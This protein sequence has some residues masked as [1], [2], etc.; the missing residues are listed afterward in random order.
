MD[1]WQPSGTDRSWTTPAN[2][3][4]GV[5]DDTKAAVFDGT[6]S[7]AD[8]GVGT[9]TAPHDLYF[10][11][12]YTGTLYIHADSV[13][14]IL[15]EAYLDNGTTAGAGNPVNIDLASGSKLKIQGTDGG[16]STIRH[17]NFTTAGTIEIA[18]SK[19]K[20][21]GTDG[22]TT[23]ASFTVDSGATFQFSNSGGSSAA[24][25]FKAGTGITNGGTIT[26]DDNNSSVAMCPGRTQNAIA[27]ANNS[28]GTINFS[29]ATATNISSFTN[30]P[31]KNTGGTV[32]ITGGGLG[33]SGLGSDASMTGGTINIDGG[34]TLALA[35]AGYVQT[36]G[37]LYAKGF[38][39]DTIYTIGVVK[40]NG[41]NVYMGD[42]STTYN[43]LRVKGPTDTYING[44]TFNFKVDATRDGICDTLELTTGTLHIDTNSGT[45][46]M[47]WT[48]NGAP[49]AGSWSVI[50][51]PNSID[52]DFTNKNIPA[53]FTET[54]NSS[55]I[56]KHA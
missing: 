5:P 41:G 28:G 49:V 42:D 30:M 4:N 44:A 8:C 7:D 29:S 48:I 19:T 9:V 31:L 53:G 56:L 38:L 50:T 15:N 37:S 46:T 12:N 25:L 47:K 10:Q 20:Y 45:S 16:T 13:L 55:W 3:S 33:F 17:A 6:K 2:W 22:G 14:S 32:N 51:T 24:L 36:G 43:T 23:Y 21:I 18:G 27:V 54:K 40:F 1:Y 11:N 34:G 52:G 39:A 26:V 35:S